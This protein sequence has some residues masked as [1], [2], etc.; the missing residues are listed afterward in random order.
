M[1]LPSDFRRT[2]H[3]RFQSARSV[4][5]V[6]TC[7]EETDKGQSLIRSGEP[8]FGKGGVGGTCAAASLR[9][10]SIVMIRQ[11]IHAAGA[12]CNEQVGSRGRLADGAGTEDDY[13]GKVLLHKRAEDLEVASI[14]GCIVA[15]RRNARRGDVWLVHEL[16]CGNTASNRVGVGEKAARLVRYTNTG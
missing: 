5:Q 3:L 8:R 11:R 2:L 14:C 4:C 10:C 12:G 1:T 6:R 9:Q 16:R 13:L 7:L 15:G